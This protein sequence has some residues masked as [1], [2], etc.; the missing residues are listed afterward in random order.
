MRTDNSHTKWLSETDNGMNKTFISTSIAVELLIGF[1][2]KTKI[3]LYD[4]KNQLIPSLLTT[5]FPGSLFFPLWCSRSRGREKDR[6]RGRG[7][8][9]DRLREVCVSS[10]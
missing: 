1:P 2:R 3:N 10:G 8:L 4:D 9:A 6:T 7:W 5:S